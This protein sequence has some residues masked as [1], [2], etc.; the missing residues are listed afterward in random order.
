MCRGLGR[1]AARPRSAAICV[2]ERQIYSGATAI[3]GSP[4]RRHGADTDA[5]PS[6]DAK[7]HLG[8]IRLAR[9]RSATARLSRGPCS[10]GC[11]AIGRTPNRTPAARSL[12]QFGAL[13]LSRKGVSAFPLRS[14]PETPFLDPTHHRCI[15]A[16]AMCRAGGGSERAAGSRGRVEH[17]EISHCG[18]RDRGCFGLGSWWGW[19]GGGTG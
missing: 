1:V 19:V 15:G 7:A 8:H 9:R 3:R 13:H 18:S 12:P 14:N 4:R 2:V 6:R 10:V 5:L 16:R 17:S 11:S